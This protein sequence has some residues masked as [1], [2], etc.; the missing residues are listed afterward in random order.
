MKI[1]RYDILGGLGRGGM[2]GVYKVAHRALGRV[3]ALKLLQPH[4]LLS[5]LM[6]ED[7][8][9]AA[10]LR[11]ARLMAVCDHRNIA[12]VWDLDE[13]RGR[14][15]MVLEY[16]CMNVGTLIGE[17]RV[18]E[19]ATRVVPPLTALDFVRQTL[20]GLE[21][22]HGRGIVHLDVKPGNIMLASDGTIKL[23][24]LGLS[25]LRGEI[26]VKP[27]G[28]KIGSPYYAAPEQEAS[29]EKADERADLYAA[30]VVL[31][32]LVTGLL[33]VEGVS[34]SALFSAQWRNFFDRALAVNPAARFENAGSMRAALDELEADLRRGLGDDCALMEPVCAMM[35]DLR[36]TP[37]RTGVKPRPFDFLD[38]LYRPL[39]FHEAEL[40]EVEGGWLDRCAGLLWGPV[41]PWPM[42]W[43]EGMASVVDDWRMPTVEEVVSLLRPGQ[44]LREFCHRPFGDR[45]L[46]LW[47][48]DRR[49]FTSAWFVDVGGGAVLAQD[50]SCRF[51][52]RLVQSV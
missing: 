32:R 25:R 44:G 16:L 7:K 20:D 37:V 30:G 23:I 26:W 3:M 4:E 22:L 38:E 45:Y 6:G 24:D 19:D 36:S 28:L 49:S 17:G 15:F 39:K 43:D 34:D 5:E 9:R 11:E 51:H 13:D 48:A 10:F 27:K 29:P 12:A 47:T 2:G 18:V 50:K 1:G 52:V 8:V 33:P 35:G 14:P 42:T 46:W 40:E 21:Y 31:H 41:S